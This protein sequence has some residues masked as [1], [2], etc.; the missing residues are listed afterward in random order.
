MNI[1]KL[2]SLWLATFPIT[3]I[4]AA[5][6]P[7]FSLGDFLF[8][9]LLIASSKNGLRNIFEFPK[10]YGLFWTYIAITYSIASLTYGGSYSAIIP[11][12]LAFFIFSLQLGFCAIQLDIKLLYKYLRVV[13]FIAIAVLCLQELSFVFLGHRFSAIV[14]F[15]KLTDGKIGADLIRIQL[16]IDRSCS[17]FREPAHTAQFLIVVYI[18]EA[19]WASKEK[20][21]TKFGV[22]LILGFLLTRSGNGMLALSFVMIIKIFDYYRMHRGIKD[23]LFL[24]F[25]LLVLLAGTVYY[26]S[27]DSGSELI[28]RTSE[29]EKTESSKSYIRIYCGLDLYSEF[30]G[31]HKLFGINNANGV[32]EMTKHSNIS[33]L[34][35]GDME[36]DLYFSCIARVLIF[37]GVIG[38]F[39]LLLFS[40]KLY[41]NNSVMGRVL[42]STFLLLS[43]ISQLY[44]SFLM[45]F[46]YS[47][48]S[49]SQYNE[50]RIMYPSRL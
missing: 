29:F 28:G 16:A 30:S 41:K 42:L 47:I 32:F 23:K 5:P 24:L 2:T 33:Y 4:Y 13:S 1:R 10:Y 3:W 8:I 48:S 15:L 11:G 43:F 40:F 18:I 49:N 22:F 21:L 19:F 39:L 31:A 34:F 12:G 36:E 25:T 44:L 38:L 6:I 50:N 14:P 46:V 37:S 9:F 7:I 45:L 26:T 20:F 35:S 17:I 27:T